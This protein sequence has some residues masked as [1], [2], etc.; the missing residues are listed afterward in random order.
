MTT[1]DPRPSTLSLCLRARQYLTRA[2]TR[3]GGLTATSTAVVHLTRVCGIIADVAEGGSIAVVR[4]DPRKLAT[5]LGCDTLD[6]DVS[7]TL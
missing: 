7:L 4:V 5:I 6:V 2:V 1:G 3:L